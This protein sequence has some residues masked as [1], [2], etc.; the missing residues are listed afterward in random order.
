MPPLVCYPF[1]GDTI[2]GSHLSAITLI[3][4]LP[5]DSVRPLIVLHQDGPLAEHLRELGLAYRLLPLPRL[6]GRDR[7][8][9]GHLLSILATAPRLLAFLRREGVALVHSN[10]GRMHLT[11]SLPARLAGVPTLW[12]QRNVFS[13]SR[14]TG[15]MIRCAA[16]VVTISDFVASGLPEVAAHKAQVM[17][18]PFELPDGLDRAA[19][20]SALRQELGLAAETPIVGLFG[21]LIDWKRPLLFVEAATRLPASLDP[22]PAFVVFGEDRGGFREAMTARAAEA[23]MKDRLFFMGFRL[24]VWPWLAACDLLVAPAVNEPFGR[25]LVEA[26][27]C[28][29]PVVASDSGGHREI[30]KDGETGLLVPPDDAP[31]FAAAIEA[32]LRD[33]S[34]RG[35]IAAQAEAAARDRFSVQ[36]H[37]AQVTEAYRGLLVAG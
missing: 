32:L 31:A 11:W 5:A 8:I 30:L 33:E 13:A 35:R 23:G 2:G 29:I 25:S 19:S 9:A 34:R 4:N 17:D 20:R 21:N 14:L 3:R 22:A 1:V 6:V 26:M 24:P 28:G 12:H 36:S 18:N 15:L 27:L 16:R 10:D 7:S 37:V